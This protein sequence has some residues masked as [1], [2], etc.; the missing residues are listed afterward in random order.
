MPIVTGN[1]S[2]FRLVL[3]DGHDE[4][5]PSLDQINGRSY[6]YVKLHRASTFID[7]G[8][9]PFSLVVCFDGTLALPAIEKYRDPE[10]ALVEFNKFLCET[11]LGGTYCE[12]MT[13]DDICLGMMT[14]NAYCKMTGASRGARSNFH[15]AIRHKHVGTLDAILL[16]KPETILVSELQKAVVIGRA[17]LAEIGSVAVETLL[18]GATFFARN[19][20]VES[21]IHLW[22]STEQIVEAI[23]RDRVL[24]APAV[25][26]IPT[27]SRLAFLKDHRTWPVATKIELLYQKGLLPE[28]TYALLNTARKARNDFAHSGATPSHLEV[29]AALDGLFQ[30]AALRITDHSDRN[31]LDEIPKLVKGRGRTYAEW[32]RQG[33][34]LEGVTHWLSIPLIPGDPG[35]G[36]AP[37]EIIEELQLKPIREKGA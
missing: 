15:N 37:Y 25:T 22:T 35:W 16:L 9:A 2:P 6:D 5:A 4:W 8:I 3:R 18:Y 20:W 27:K 26:G 30:M 19:Q 12:A 32:D 7:I 13:P 23:W 24:S 17:R 1:H 10:N 11:L 29:E 33:K 14:F 28:Q 21:L 36:D 31:A 34:P